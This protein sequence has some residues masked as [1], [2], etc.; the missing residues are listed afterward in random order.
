VRGKLITVVVRSTSLIG[1]TMQPLRGQAATTPDAATVVGVN[2]SSDTVTLA[3]VNDHVE[4]L[5]VPDS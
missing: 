5:A 4:T 3:D 1:G 2:P